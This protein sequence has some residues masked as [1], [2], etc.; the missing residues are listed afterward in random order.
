MVS[1]V[2]SCPLLSTTSTTECTVIGPIAPPAI[3]HPQIVT[4]DLLIFNLSLLICLLDDFM[5][6]LVTFL[7]TISC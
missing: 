4:V 1:L 5:A 2:L 6:R 7:R 3:L